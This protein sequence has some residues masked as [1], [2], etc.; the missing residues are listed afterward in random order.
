MTGA[1]GFVGSCLRRILPFNPL[2]LE[3]GP[4][5]D[6]RK[7]SEVRAA[8]RSQAPD[9]VVH[10]AAQSFVPRSF[11][12]PLETYETNFLGTLNLLDA[13]K[14]TSF[15][16]VFLFVGSGDMYG[17]VPPEH[18][19]IKEDRA[20]HPRNPYAVSK[21]AAEALCFQW[22]ATERFK[23]VMARPFN[24]IGPGQSERFAVSGFAKQIIEIKKGRREPTLSV[25]DIHVTRDF[26][27]VR[28]IVRAYQLLIEHGE[29][30]ESYNVCS[31]IET[32]LREIVNRLMDIAGVQASIKQDSS[33]FRSTEQRRQVGCFCKLNRTTGW[34]PS[35]A[36][37]RSLREI[38]SYWEKELE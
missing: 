20:L 7:P 24:H 25:G 12:D 38:L 27:D 23:I 37:D 33:L 17:L 5:I 16:G 6:L 14:Q 31:G 32:P 13:L 3:G 26:T 1:N 4:A 15:S 36:L 29:N 11:L 8:V 18:I 35:I 22:S 19:P 28:D 30:G 10:L 9:V 2:S 34:S 21:V